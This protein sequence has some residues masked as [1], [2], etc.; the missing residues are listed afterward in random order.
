[1]LRRDLSLQLL[2]LYLLF[3]GPVV[4]ASVIFDRQA[5]QR[6]ESDVEASDQAL[7]RAIALETS[8]A[9]DDRM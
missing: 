7:A 4:I 3:V 8:A 6:L 5:T 1:M 9:L 2:A